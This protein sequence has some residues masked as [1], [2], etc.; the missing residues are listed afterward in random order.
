VDLKATR[1]AEETLT[2]TVQTPELAHFG[3]TPFAEVVIR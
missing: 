1:M 2:K 3:Y